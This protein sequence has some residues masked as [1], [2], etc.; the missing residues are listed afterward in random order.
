MVRTKRRGAAGPGK[1]HWLVRPATIR[2]L[3]IGFIA[4][5][6][7]LLLANFAIHPKGHFGIDGTFGF[8]AWFGFLSCVAMVIGSK[9]LG[10]FLKRKDSYYDSP[11]TFAPQDGELGG[12][13]N[14]GNAP[15]KGARR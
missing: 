8:F 15:G 5:L 13:G 1:L 7:L 11:P 3:W 6:V 4:V 12:G 14:G 10:V 9:V 2:G